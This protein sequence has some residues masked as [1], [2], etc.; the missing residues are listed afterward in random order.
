MAEPPWRVDGISFGQE[1]VDLFD[2]EVEVSIALHQH[3][4]QAIPDPITAK[5]DIIRVT[6]GSDSGSPSKFIGI[7]E[8]RDRRRCVWIAC[9]V[10]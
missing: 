6:A 2:L 4:E 3:I 7:G 9:A 5:L 10:T 1:I 8:F